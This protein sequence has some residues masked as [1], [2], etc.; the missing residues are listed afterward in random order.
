MATLPVDLVLNDAR[1]H[2]AHH[3]SLHTTYNNAQIAVLGVEGTLVT[4]TGKMRFQFP[5]AATILGISAAIDTPPTGASVI[6][7]VNTIPSGSTTRTTIYST[8][9][10]RPTIV[11]GAYN[12]TAETVPNTTA[13]AAKA[14][15][16]IDVDQIGSTTAGIDLTVMVRYQI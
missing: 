10:N 1:D 8:Q 7:D 9:G 3:N 15:L 14:S 12:T 5:V 11:A 6:V 16:T 2:V 13:F 4:G